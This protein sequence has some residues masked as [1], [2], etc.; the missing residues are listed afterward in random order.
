MAPKGTR[1]EVRRYKAEAERHSH[2]HHQIVLPLSGALEMDVGGAFDAVTA[3]RAVAIPSGQLHSFAGTRDNALLVVD[4]GAA[5]GLRDR[6][7]LRFWSAAAEQPFI[8]LEPSFR[9]FCEFIAGQA[10][11]VGYQGLRA[12][13]T[14]DFMVEALARGVGLEP[15]PLPPPLARAVAFIEAHHDRPIALADV[16]RH[17]GL[18]ESR[19]NAHFHERFGVAP[20]R[21]LARQRLRQAEV[22]LTETELPVAEVALR[23][24]YGDQSAFARAFQRETGE[25]PA[26]FRRARRAL[27]E[28]RH[29]ER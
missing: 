5:G 3:D 1:I 8:G 11:T 13:V 12:E 22:L 19:L 25:P 21:Y 24:G 10:P 20:G 9:G 14:G 17:A 16:A 28:D 27:R 26:A 4:L 23:V 7:H 15:N 6:E 2:D 18:S 29:K